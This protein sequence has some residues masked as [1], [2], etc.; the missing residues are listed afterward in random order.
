VMLGYLGIFVAGAAALVRF[1]LFL[2]VL[3]STLSFGVALLVTEM[4]LEP[5]ESDE[6]QGSVLLWKGISPHPDTSLHQFYA[7]KSRVLHAYPDDP[8]GYFER[9]DPLEMR[10][11]LRLSG[12]SAKAALV[13]GSDNPG[14]L[15]V[16]IASAPTRTA[17][18]IQLVEQGLSVTRGDALT[19]RFRARADR[20]RSIGVALIRGWAPWNNLGYSGTI[21]IDTVWRNFDIPIVVTE[22]ELWGQLQFNLGAESSSVELSGIALVNVASGDTIRSNFPYA[23]R[24]WFNDMGCRDRDYPLER[25][26]GTWRILALGDSYT[27]GVGVHARDVFTE[28][29]EELLNGA[30]SRG[31][32]TY[33]VINCGVSGYSTE[34]ELILYQRHAARYHPDLVLLTMVWND[35]RSYLEDV[36]LGFRERRRDRLFRTWRL[37]DQALADR[38]VRHH[39]YS[40]AM[41]A[42]EGLRKAVE[43][44]GSR[45][46]VI[47]GKNQDAHE[48]DP[49][50]DAV[51]GSVDTLALPVLDLW[52]RLRTEP[53][54][55]MT[56]LPDWDGHPNER[57]HAIIAREIGRFLEEKGLLY[58]RG[59][60]SVP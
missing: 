49:L 19:V 34:D 24:Y 37:L 60:A 35:D 11:D 41:R 43:A 6:P 8:R 28:R 44:R 57:A 53:Y 3:L 59:N 4:I 50:I 30:R 58:P 25:T 36:Q 20:P 55:E 16:E 5:R 54:R 33:E 12:T 27:M 29:L 40:N 1:S 42:L 21:G 46:V 47:I 51:Y 52:R 23:V 56:V 15:R 26:A 17:W 48:W 45:L 39:D 18:H 13:R 22:T 10:W 32:P 38:R 31:M 9:P 7:P 2:P 14:M